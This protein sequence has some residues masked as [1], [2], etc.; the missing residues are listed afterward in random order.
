MDGE[1]P[2]RP[3]RARK[4]YDAERP[5]MR[6]EMR[7][8]DPRSA[9]ERRAAEIL[10]NLGGNVDEGVDEFRTPKAP[11]GWTYE[12]KRKTVMGQE[13]HAYQTALART[14]WEPVV[15]SRHPE[16]MPIN[17]QGAIERKGMV[18]MERPQIVT[19]QVKD[20]DYRRA[21]GQ[22]RAKEQQLT[23]APQGQFGREHSQA[24]PKINKSYEPMPV[25]KD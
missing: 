2:A 16:M 20:A 21:R 10:G 22:I 14:G 6:P 23:Q 19:D 4:N 12:W 13:D 11:D 17:A 5:A 8:D 25:P 18:L 7:G 3:G 24:Q 15:A 9:A 1:K